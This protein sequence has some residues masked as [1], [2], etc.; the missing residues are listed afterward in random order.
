[1]VHSCSRFLFFLPLPQHLFS[2]YPGHVQKYLHLLTAE[3]AQWYARPILSA[4]KYF[5][6]T[7]NMEGNKFPKLKCVFYDPQIHFFLYF[8]NESVDLVKQF[9]KKIILRKII[10]KLHNS[11]SVQKFVSGKK[12]FL[13]KVTQIITFILNPLR[14]SFCFCKE[15][16]SLR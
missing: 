2:V 10:S 8:V 12:H 6:S 5:S 15:L 3:T 9:K 14:E 11:V 1:M 13:H 7:N 4:F 16:M